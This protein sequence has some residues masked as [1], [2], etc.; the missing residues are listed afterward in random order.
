MNLVLLDPKSFVKIH[1]HCACAQEVAYFEIL[2][3]DH[4]F[5]Y[6]K[7]GKAVSLDFEWIINPDGL[8]L[9]LDSS[10]GFEAFDPGDAY[11]VLSDMA[12]ALNFLGFR[13]ETDGKLPHDRE[14]KKAN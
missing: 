9:Y 12:R 2:S 4:R 10:R 11:D 13:T 7:E 3:G 1:P 8:V 14:G 6:S 5:R